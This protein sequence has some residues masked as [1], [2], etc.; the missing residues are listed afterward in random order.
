[1]ENK[2]DGK[3]GDAE[4]EPQHEIEEGEV[5]TADGDKS[6]EPFYDKVQNFVTFRFGLEKFFGQ[7]LNRILTILYLHIDQT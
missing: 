7:V 5:Q 1:L 3:N 4:E 2:D 6:A